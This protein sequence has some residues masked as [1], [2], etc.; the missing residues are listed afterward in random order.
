M[1]QLPEHGPC[2]VCGTANPQSMGVRW[3]IQDD[4]TIYGEVTLD[5]HQQGP[6]GHGHGGASAALLDEAMGTAVWA[7]GHMV[8]AANLNV[9][10]RRPVPLG[11]LLKITAMVVDK[12]GRKLYTRAEL[13]LPDGHIAVKATGLFVE[14][15]QLFTAVANQFIGLLPDA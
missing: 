8:L 9:D 5:I 13:A 10:F 15:P 11:V 2:F 4:G 7:A 6:P 1:K 12:S 3:F 14:A